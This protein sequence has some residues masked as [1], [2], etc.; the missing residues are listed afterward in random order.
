MAIRRNRLTSMF[1]TS[2][3]SPATWARRGALLT[4]LLS[5][6]HAPAIVISSPHTGLSVQVDQHTGIYRVGI[7]N[8]TWMFAGQFD[9][10]IT[11]VVVSR[12]RDSVG[13]Y[14]QLAFEW[15]AKQS[16]M[17]GQ[18]RLYDE[19]PLVWFADTC[20]MAVESA[21]APF[22][23]FKAMPGGLHSFSYGMNT[24][25]P[26][27]F[28]ANPVSTPWL[29][30]DD[31]ANALVISPASHFM[32]ASMSGD[33]QHQMASGLNAQ[34]HGVPAGFTQQTVMAF[35]QGINRTWDSWGD[36]LVQWTGSKRPGNEAD[37]SLKYLGY[38]TDNGAA[39]YYN[40]DQSKGY[41]GTLEAL[42]EHFRQ[43]Q[44]P[45]RYLQL[46]SWWYYKSFTDPDGKPGKTKAPG[47]PEGEWNRYGGLMEY[48]AHTDLFPN[49]LGAFQK[50]IDL[51][52][53]THNR[54]IDPAS[55]YH[56]RY[57]IS[58]LAAVDPQWWQDIAA[59]LKA[60]GVVTYEQDWLDRIYKYSPG[61]SSNLDTAEAFLDN[62]ARA[63]RAKGI[64]LQY[65]MPYPCFFLQGSR[66][67][68]LTTIRTSDDRFNPDRWNNFLYTSR[69]AASMGIWPWADVYR[70]TETN[71]VLLSTLSAGPVGIGDPSGAEDKG[72]I[73]KAVRAD[74]VIVKPDVSIVP[75]DQSYIADAQHFASP[76]VAGTHTD[77]D[78]L[79]TGYV[80]A[81]NRSKTNAL[82]AKFSPSELGLTGMV[83]VFDYFAGTARRLPA[84]DTFSASLAGQAAAFY[85]VAPVGG[86]GIAFL[87]DRDKFV[88]TGRQRIT[89]LRDESGRLTVGVVFAKSEESVTLHG[90]ALRAPKV[91]VQSG[92]AGA[93]QFDPATGH[94]TL[95]LRPDMTLPTDESAGD[96]VRHLTAVLETPTD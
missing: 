63:C 35:G 66:Y 21:P 81:F 11:N 34:L 12:G 78:G 75:L 72:N 7:R 61:F 73:L 24:F 68:N 38:W 94:F 36:A 65:C 60:S 16:P 23:A 18:V 32:V 14:Q 6:V 96:P 54:W 57:N 53:I 31:H 59:Y 77:H 25:A 22:P 62:M 39:Y 71:N 3:F 42:M 40:Y 26:P 80:F 4:L 64:T 15:H 91:S 47:L 29:L 92:V 30:F 17:S 48:K 85:V 93:V 88:S 41:A 55:P 33:G 49:G 87:G 46:D 74:G 9:V 20:G 37:T 5:G 43:E 95:E 89:S 52:L 67:P 1:E 58:G 76:L 83:Y 10:P 44:V 19:K 13:A 51:P 2:I 69:L 56:Q 28:A 90:Y 86:S 82:P 84:G 45:V 27:Q 79:R 8:P 50:S 70:S